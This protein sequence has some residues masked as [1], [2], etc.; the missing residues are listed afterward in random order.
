[1]DYIF[2]IHAKLVILERNINYNDI[3]TVIENPD[4]ISDDSF[5]DDLEH[6]LKKIVH[7]SN[8]VLRVIVKRRSNPLLIITAYYDRTMRGKL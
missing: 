5:D 1:M 6:R 2:T 8:R 7:N 3:C 4:L